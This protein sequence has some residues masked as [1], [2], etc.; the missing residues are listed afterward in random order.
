[1]SEDTGTIRSIQ[2]C[3]GER[4]PMRQL[5]ESELVDGG[6]PGDAHFAPGSIRQ[7]LL[8]EAETLAALGIEPGTVKENLTVEGVS[9]MD[10][11]TGTRLEVGDAELE[12]TKECEPCSR[13][14]EIRDGLRAELLGQR[15]MLA[16]VTR[17][18]TVRRGDPVRVLHPAPAG[19]DTTPGSG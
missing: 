12:V 13:M 8:I 1:M 17:S 2:T 10:L 14:D 7:L 4:K 16:R 15:G 6:I 19:G 18:G 3:P 5:E 9:L 11:Q